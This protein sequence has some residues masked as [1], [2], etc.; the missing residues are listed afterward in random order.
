MKRIFVFVFSII[1][2]IY[3]FVTNVILK[4]I[5]P[6]ELNIE[7]KNIDVVEEEY[8]DC[9]QANKRD[10][11]FVESGKIKMKR[12]DFV[13]KKQSIPHALFQKYGL[14]QQLSEKEARE[15]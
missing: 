8:H 10:I 3:C 13:I 15:I 4:K 1:I 7:E 6:Y 2:I 9:I 12:K 14:G 5:N 11:T